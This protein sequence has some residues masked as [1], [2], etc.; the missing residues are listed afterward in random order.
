[1]RATVKALKLLPYDPILWGLKSSWPVLRRGSVAE[2]LNQK[3]PQQTPKN[4]GLWVSDLDV[5]MLRALGASKCTS[6]CGF[7]CS[8]WGS[9][10]QGP[11]QTVQGLGFGGFGI[12]VATPSPR[13]R[14]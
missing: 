12:R 4:L 5:L 3:T 10:A 1:M 14:S 13:E 7:F 11:G 8:V 2:A 9:G 6:C